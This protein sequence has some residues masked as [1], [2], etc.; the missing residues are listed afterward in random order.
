TGMTGL[1]IIEAILAGERNP[2]TLAKL[3]DGRIKAT[4][5]TIAKSWVGDYRRE[6]LFTL[7]QSLAAYRHYQKLISACD[8]EIEQYRET[9]KSKADPPED[10]KRESQDGQK[11]RDGKPTFDL[12]S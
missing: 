4:E 12:Q 7:G 10:P 3:P 8:K 5:S 11:T 6:H 9:F 2:Q 1:A